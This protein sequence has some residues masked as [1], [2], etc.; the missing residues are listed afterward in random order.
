MSALRLSF[1]LVAGSSH[2]CLLL[3]AQMQDYLQLDAL[4]IALQMA[5]SVP[6]YK[7]W[8]YIV[9]GFNLAAGMS[10]SRAVGVSFY[11]GSQ[12]G[13]GL[14]LAIAPSGC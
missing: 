13:H 12:H 9:T 11:C 4:Q 6:N 7:A 10:A 1:V 3:G 14:S 5:L 2:T 8:T